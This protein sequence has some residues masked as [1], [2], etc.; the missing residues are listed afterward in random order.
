MSKANN[1]IADS[2]TKRLKRQIFPSRKT[3]AMFILIITAIGLVSTFQGISEAWAWEVAKALININGLLM[4]F[5]ILGITVFSKSGF[6]RTMFRKSVEESA[7]EFISHLQYLGKNLEEYTAEGLAEK[8]FFSL[9]YPFLDVVLLR[10]VFLFSMKYLLV[11]IGFALCLFG[12]N[13]ETSS[14]PFLKTLFSLFFS[15]ALACFVWGAYFIMYAVRTILEKGTEI[16][17]KKGL[18]I[19]ISTFEKKLKDLGKQDKGK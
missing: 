11:S 19:S 16:N 18:E 3:S 13:A 5:C 17:V 6:S 2:I 4:G 7:T 9:L 12:V 15:F 10:E 1:E 14:N 8:F